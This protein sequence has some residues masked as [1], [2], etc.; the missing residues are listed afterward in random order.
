PVDRAT[1]E[2]LEI[3]K[4]LRFP[5]LANQRWSSLP[6]QPRHQVKGF[7]LVD[8]DGDGIP[9]TYLPGTSNFG[10]GHLRSTKPTFVPIACHVRGGWSHRVARQRSPPRPPRGVTARRRPQRTAAR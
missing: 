6:A 10:V 9:D 1:T 3:Q 7:L 4:S 8:T 5:P 2:R